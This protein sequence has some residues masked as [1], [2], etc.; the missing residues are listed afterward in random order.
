MSQFGRSAFSGL[1]SRD[2][3]LTAEPGSVYFR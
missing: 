1:K 3:A 2:P